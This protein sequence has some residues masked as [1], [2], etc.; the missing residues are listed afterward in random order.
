MQVTV[1]TKP[2]RDA[3]LSIASFA[4]Q[5]SPKEVLQM[6]KMTVA[7]DAITME[8]T[9]L[10]TSARIVLREGFDCHNAGEVLLATRYVTQ[11]LRETTDEYLEFSTDGSSLKICGKVSKFSFPTRD[12]KEYPSVES[13][14]ADMYHV[15]TKRS[16][17]TALNRT[18]FACDMGS[19]RFALGGLLLDLTADEC[20]IIGTDGR[21]LAKAIIQAEQV[22]GHKGNGTPILPQASAVAL[23]RFLSSASDDAEVRIS[24]RA[25]DIIVSIDES[26]IFARRLEGRYPNWEKIIPTDD[27]AGQIEIA[28]GTLSALTRQAAITTDRETRGI[29]YAFSEGEFVVQ[30]ESAEYGSS[31]VRS[32]CSVDGEDQSARLDNSYILDFCKA[33]DMQDQVSIGMYGSGPVRMMHD[34]YLYIVMPMARDNK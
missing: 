1:E 20:R 19:T 31:D 15:T 8:A 18:I 14:N 12:P 13:I 25:N 16:L 7:P 28:C 21:R 30:S 10:D 2:F 4:P 6:V 27:P 29:E 11:V 34:D 3:Y 33:L 17:A 23:S 5:R 32:P 26:T 22:G 9:N 24:I